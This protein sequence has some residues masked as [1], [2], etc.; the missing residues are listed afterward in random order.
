[1]PSS[2]V[3]D[4]DLSFTSVFWRTLFQMQGTRFN[5]SSAYHPQTDG[6]T[7]VVNK[8]LEMYLR[9]FT[10]DY[11]KQW[12]NWLP[13]V[14]FCYNTSIHLATCLTPFEVVYGRPP[15]TLLSYVRGTTRV[16]SVDKILCDRDLLLKQVKAHLHEAQ[17]RMK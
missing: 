2:I 12:Y 8:T 9:C 5:Y 6:Q 4:R 10:G 16:E 13:W 1:M 3:C 7:K 15:P 11:P 14:E 17:N